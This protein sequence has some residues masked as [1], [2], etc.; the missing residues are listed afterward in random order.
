MEG[1]LNN[2]QIEYVLFHLSYHARIKPD[3]YNAFV[4]TSV[5]KEIDLYENKIVFLLSKE[6]LVVEN[7]D[8][9]GDV[10]VLFPVSG[11]KSFYIQKNGNIIFLHDI[12]KSAFYLLSGYQE[13]DSAESDFLG[14]YPFENS[15]QAK[16]GFANRP[17][18][19][20]YFQE[21]MNG[22]EEFCRPRN[23]EFKRKNTFT[24]FAFFLSHDVD[25][26]KYYTLNTFLYTVKQFL[27]LSI[28]GKSR[29][30]LLNDLLRIGARILNVFDHSD[31]YWNFEYLCESELKMG[32]RSTWFFL[33][34]DQKHVDSYYR[35]GNK[36]IR[37]LISYLA[38]KGHE[39]GLHGTVR[40]HNSLMSMKDLLQEFKSVTGKPCSGIRQHRLMWEHPATA[41]IHDAAGLSYDSTLGFAAHE[42]FR[43]SYC[44]PF[45]LFDFK[46][47]KMLSV[48]EIPLNL[49]DSTLFHYRKLTAS[50][51]IEAVQT[52]LSEIIKFGGVFTILW[53]NSYLSE[54][55][56]PGIGDFYKSILKRITDENPEVLLGREITERLST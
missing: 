2:T 29:M 28:S 32:I 5:E 42:G 24:P 14:R 36:K 6:T 47:N 44:H 48:W 11:E 39:I 9:I 8:W 19:N 1:L 27:G 10:P 52:L 22:F 34:R 55:E 15:I 38:E 31:P 49:M 20:Y 50:D 33:P 40:S 26:I 17:V 7:V 13:Q 3:L 51:G 18:V 54:R 56:I 23:I 30:Q 43:N 41:V 35:L 46:N 45:R 37:K 16:L 53:H 21:I 12:I 4:F 25:R